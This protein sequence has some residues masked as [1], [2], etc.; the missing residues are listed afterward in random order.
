M[1]LEFGSHKSKLVEVLRTGACSKRAQLSDD[2]W[3]PPGHL[4]RRQRPV[5][6]RLHQ[7]AA[8]ADCPTTCPPTASLGEKIAAV[9]ARRCAGCHEAGDVSRLDWI[10]LGRPRASRF[11]A[12]PLAKA[13][14][15]SGKCPTP[16]YASTDDPD[17]RRFARWSRQPRTRLGNCRGGI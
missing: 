11:L 12:A 8:A 5:P 14:G 13:Q 6:R 7:Q 15:G 10:D 3:L 4:D 2:D 16:P 9:H 1:P 17:Y